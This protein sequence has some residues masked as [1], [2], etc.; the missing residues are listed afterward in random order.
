MLAAK[1]VLLIKCLDK[2][3]ATYGTIRSLYSH[4]PCKVCGN[5]EHS[6]NDYLKT[7][8]ATLNNNN[9]GLRPQGGLGWN[10]SHQQYQEGK[11][12]KHRGTT[13]NHRL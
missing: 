11:D 9:N 4:I 6:G 7:H 1:L 10:Q 8:E 3:G 5:F 13:P 2:K 12:K